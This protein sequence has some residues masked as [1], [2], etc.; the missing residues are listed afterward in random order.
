MGM[1]NEEREERKE[2][3]NDC[4]EREENTSVRGICGSR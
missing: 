2:K 3:D 4:W 1:E